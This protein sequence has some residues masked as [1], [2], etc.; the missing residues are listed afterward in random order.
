MYFAI[1]SEETAIISPHALD[2][3]VLKN[4]REGACLLRSMN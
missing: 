2:R 3:L 1:I 4:E